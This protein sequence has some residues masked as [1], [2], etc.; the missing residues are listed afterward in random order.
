MILRAVVMWP[1]Q[2][3]RGDR[4]GDLPRQPHRRPAQREQPPAAN[5][6]KPSQELNDFP[7]SP[8]GFTHG[9]TTPLIWPPA[10]S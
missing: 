2:Q 4:V 10:A 3:V 6:T 9:G 5:G 8:K 1:G 7:G